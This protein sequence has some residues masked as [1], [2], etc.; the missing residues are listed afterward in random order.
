MVWLKDISHLASR[1][2]EEG[3]WGIKLPISLHYLAGSGRGAGRRVVF[4]PLG[5][6]LFF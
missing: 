2:G 5:E 1:E 6:A 3:E 4:P